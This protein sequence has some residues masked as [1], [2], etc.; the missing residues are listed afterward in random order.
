VYRNLDRMVQLGTV[1]KLTV[2]GDSRT[3]YELTGD[4][5]HHHVVCRNCSR[6][7]QFDLCPLDGF[8]RRLEEQTGFRFDDHTLEV[9]GL[10]ADC[11]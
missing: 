4:G 9:S 2:L 5:H 6:V 10:C 1:R 8:V 11:R 7:V 3:R